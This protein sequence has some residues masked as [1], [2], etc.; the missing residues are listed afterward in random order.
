MIS[1]AE[2]CFAELDLNSGFIEE[3]Q[4]FETILILNRFQTAPRNL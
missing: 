1:F 3:I 2:F 4:N